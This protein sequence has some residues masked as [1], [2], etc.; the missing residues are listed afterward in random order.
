MDG[1]SDS[2]SFPLADVL[3]I[4]TGRLLPRRHMDG[5]YELLGYMTGQDL[6]THQLGVAADRCGP[7]LRE[8]HPLLNALTPPPSGDL[9]DL[10]A[11]LVE[12]ERVHGEALLVRPLADWV[13]RD[14]I[15]DACDMV[16]AEKV[17]VVPVDC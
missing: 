5:M 16:G 11:W 12:A 15:E 13:R 4:T 6:Y 17:F 14:P 1:M 10:M 2:R 9:A 3:S 7:A 8:Q